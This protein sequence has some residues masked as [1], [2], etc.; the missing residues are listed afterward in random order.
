MATGSDGERPAP[1]SGGGARQAPPDVPANI[2]AAPTTPLP[3]LA[4][5]HRGPATLLTRLPDRAAVVAFLRNWWLATASGALIVISVVT[6]ATVLVTRDGGGAQPASAEAAAAAEATSDPESEPEPEPEEPAPT[7]A[8][9]T[10]TPSP[11]ASTRRPATTPIDRIAAL[12]VT[13]QQLIDSGD[14]DRRAGREILRT[15]ASIS[16]AVRKGRNEQAVKRLRDLD[17]RLEKLRDDRKLSRSGF[18]ALDVLQPIIRS[19]R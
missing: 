10:T 2:V 13:T 3:K 17:K 9:P 14:L 6:V 19:L 15:L 7:S 12:A 8:A 5:R 1:V 18:E 16:S 4:G 11:S